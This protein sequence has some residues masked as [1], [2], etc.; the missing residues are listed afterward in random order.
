[1]IRIGHLTLVEDA[2]A[3]AGGLGAKSAN[4]VMHAREPLRAQE[5]DLLQGLEVLDDF[6]KSVV[7]LPNGPVHVDLDRL[8]SFGGVGVSV[9]FWFC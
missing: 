5:V 6:F 9:L 4:Y 7:Q 1:V 8:Q 3:F 2:P